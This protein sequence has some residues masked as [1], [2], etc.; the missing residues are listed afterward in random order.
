MGNLLCLFLGVPSSDLRVGLDSALKFSFLFSSIIPSRPSVPQ[1]ALAIALSLRCSHA[2]RSRLHQISSSTSPAP[3]SPPK[4]PQSS[5]P[6]PRPPT[7]APTLR[8]TQ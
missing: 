7:D 5:I 6:S 8:S 2:H 3:D 1:S 4:I